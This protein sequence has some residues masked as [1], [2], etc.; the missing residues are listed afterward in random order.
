MQNPNSSVLTKHDLA[1]SCKRH[2]C[3]IK[4]QDVPSSFCVILI[5]PPESLVINV[6]H[7]N[8]CNINICNY[9]LK[10]NKS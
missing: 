1:V 4:W 10:A 6:I 3:C 2:T 5:G 7:K 8:T 9:V